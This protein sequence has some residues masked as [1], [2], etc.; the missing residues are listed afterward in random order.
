MDAIVEGSVMVSGQKVQVNVQ[1]I[2]ARTDRNLWA[3]S[4]ERDLRD[5][6]ALQSELA[7]AIAREIKIVVTPAEQARLALTRPVNPEAY[8]LVLRARSLWNKRTEADLLRA[9]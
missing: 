8:Q 5:I 6:L 7:R 2:E 9:K 3:Q 4:Y 1:L